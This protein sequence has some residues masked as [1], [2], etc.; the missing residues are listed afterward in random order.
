MAGRCYAS[1]RFPDGKSG[2]KYEEGQAPM[3][4]HQLEILSTVI[5]VALSLAIV[6]VF[7]ILTRGY[8]HRERGVPFIR[9]GRAGAEPVN[10]PWHTKLLLFAVTV[11]LLL[12]VAL[13]ILQVAGV[14][15]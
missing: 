1:R 9:V 4:R 11:C 10:A 5:M 2:A 15:A 3:D 13:T 8:L 12:V 7:V 6:G 14:L